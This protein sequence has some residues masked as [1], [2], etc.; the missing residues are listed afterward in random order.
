MTFQGHV[1]EGVVHLDNGATLPDGAAVRGGLVAAR[2]ACS[3]LPVEED[4][5]AWAKRNIAEGIRLSQEAFRRDLPELLKQKKLYHQWIANHRHQ[6]IGIA[7][8]G[9]K[10][11][12]ECFKRGLADDEFYIGWI[13]TCELEVEEEVVPRPQHFAERDHEDS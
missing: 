13:D 5:T 12:D 10:L 11:L 9:H 1:K 4:A 2:P 8:S 6:R 7:D 3:P